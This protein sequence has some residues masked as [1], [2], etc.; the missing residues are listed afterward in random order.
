MSRLRVRK[1]IILCCLW[2]ITAVPG[3]AQAGKLDQASK[4]ARQGAP[5]SSS[6]SSGSASGKSNGGADAFFYIV[7]APWWVPYSVV[8]ADRAR[9]S[10]ERTRFAPYPFA[11]GYDGHIVE[12]FPP[13]SE[14]EQSY[15][16]AV[17]AEREL[18][19]KP[20]GLPVAAVVGAE[21]GIGLTDGIFR[22]GIAGR[23]MIP[24]RL[25]LDSDW[26]LFR[27]I[28]G[29][30]TDRLWLGREHLSLRFAESSRVVFR[31]GIGPQHL[32]DAKGC[33]HGIDVNWGF[34]VF[35]VRPVVFSLEGDIGNAGEAFALGVRGRIGF[36][37]GPIE[38][39]VGY[40]QRRIGTV[41]LGGPYL[42]LSTWF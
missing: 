42:G 37:L 25:E 23:F 4:E 15:Y 13:L 8:E 21:S 35:P 38:V 14:T 26:S 22:F 19:T 10:A 32:C 40:H 31:S 5:R 1:T 27:E 36:L 12:P 16:E 9:G 17:E 33:V 3:L 30:G 20:R 7:T 41:D 2:F 24:M 34:E 18:Q 29:S 28:S 6:R 11:T 39:G